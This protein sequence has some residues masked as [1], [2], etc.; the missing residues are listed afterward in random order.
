MEN[1]SIHDRIFSGIACLLLFCSACSAPESN[2]QIASSAP[3]SCPVQPEF[4]LSSQDVKEVSLTNPIVVTGRVRSSQSLGYHFPAKAGQT[5]LMESEQDLCLWVYTQQSVLLD[6]F[7]IPEDGNYMLQV[8]VVQGVKTF[9]LSMHLAEDSVVSTLSPEIPD[10][11]PPSPTQSFLDAPISPPPAP[12]P[13]RNIEDSRPLPTTAPIA[14]SNAIALIES[15]YVFLSN[16]QFDRANQIY[17]NPLAEQFT[18]SF[19]Q[20]FS[21]VTVA[22]LYVTSRTE[23]S[24]NFEGTNTY[25]WPDGST[26]REA[27]SYTVRRIDT[28]LKITSSEFIE[29]LKFR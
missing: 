27:R 16:K 2:S 22:N 17:S 13:D 4:A 25:V 11:A 28:S 24:I 18:P 5:L 10:T 3:K 19:F 8:S 7:E 29:V 1:L 23:N 26:Q 6:E 12:I 15:L 9:Q 14:E 20:K 21:R